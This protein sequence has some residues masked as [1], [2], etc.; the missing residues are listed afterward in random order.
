MRITN[1]SLER[2]LNIKLENGLDATVYSMASTKIVSLVNAHFPAN[3][4]PNLPKTKTHFLV[5]EVTVAAEKVYLFYYA[6]PAIARCKRVQELQNHLKFMLTGI[7]YAIY[8]GRLYFSYPRIYVTGARTQ[9]TCNADDS[10]LRV[11]ARA[12]E[13]KVSPK[14]ACLL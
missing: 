5:V 11:I 3:R 9:Y 12:V 6:N 4:W 13:Q 10:A 8:N 14:I 7:Y 2:G 1:E